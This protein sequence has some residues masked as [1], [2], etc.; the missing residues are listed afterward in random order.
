MN[1]TTFNAQIEESTAKIIPNVLETMLSFKASPCGP[2]ELPEKGVRVTGSIGL[3]GEEIVGAIY[4]H[5]SEPF[6]KLAAR[7]LLGLGEGEESAESDVNDVVGELC[8]MIAGGFK[9]EL[10]DAGLACAISA[11]AIIRGSHFTIQPS[12]EL[13][14]WRLSYECH[15]HRLTVE[16]HLQHQ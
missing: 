16:L 15:G 8:N 6:A 9:S 2:S 14:A 11:P 13:Q 3:A 1:P 7:T 5:L 4:L 12:Q 10:C